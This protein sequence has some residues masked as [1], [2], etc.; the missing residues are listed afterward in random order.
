MLFAHTIFASKHITRRSEMRI[1]VDRV[2][3][4]GLCRRGVLSIFF[5]FVVCGG[6]TIFYCRREMKGRGQ[7]VN[8]TGR[9]T[10][11]RRNSQLKLIIDNQP[12]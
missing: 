12:A 4:S 2:W 5:V 1:C 7:G 6:Q 3:L 10:T 11:H 9:E 8:P